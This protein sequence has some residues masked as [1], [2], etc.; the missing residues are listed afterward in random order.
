MAFVTLEDET[1]LVES[2]WFPDAYRRY[3]PLLERDQPLTLCGR[4]SEEFGV[5]VLEVD[6]AT[7]LPLD[8][9]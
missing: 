3:G 6:R 2:V 7:A 8:G 4:I 9:G 1:G 5:A